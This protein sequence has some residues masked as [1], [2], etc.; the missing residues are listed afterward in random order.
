MI[1]YQLNGDITSKG[2]TLVYCGT[3]NGNSLR[4]LARQYETIYAFEPDPEMFAMCKGIMDGISGAHIFN[5]ACSDKNGKATLYITPNRVATSL[6][7]S[8]AI[9][10]PAGTPYGGDTG[11][12][13]PNDKSIKQVEVETINLGEFLKAKGVDTIDY[14]VS[15]C[16]GSDL[17]I[18]RTMGDYL[19][20]KKIKKLHLETFADVQLYEGLDNKFSGFKAILEPNYQIE[21][22]VL[23]RIGQ[24]VTDEKDIPAE[25]LEW[26]TTWAVKP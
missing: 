20:Q 6:G 11:R 21:A 1:T 8:A 13:H 23:G 15:D 16:Q 26:D 14:Y 2:K 9:W 10:C 4:A 7:E 18:L 3:N 24:I 22:I 19:S 25:E 17:T 12:Y 5:L